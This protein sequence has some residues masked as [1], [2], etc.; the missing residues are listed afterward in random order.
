MDASNHREP[1]AGNAGTEDPV[2]LRVSLVDLGDLAVE[3][4]AR[5]GRLRFRARGQ[6]MRPAIPDGTELELSCLDR[7]P[8]RGDILC[9]RTAS[10]EIVVHR[11]VGVA[12]NW[13]ELWGDATSTSDS[14]VPREAIL[15]LVRPVDVASARTKRTRVLWSIASRCPRPIAS[16]LRRI[17]ATAWLSD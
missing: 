13:V 10:G 14:R 4:L 16:L 5:R 15:G 2:E 3:L 9:A 11:V 1:F 8:R 12:K 17:L 6:S 7:P